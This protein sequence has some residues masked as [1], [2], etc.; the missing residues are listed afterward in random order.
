MIS[1]HKRAA[2]YD[3]DIPIVALGVDDTGDAPRPLRTYQL[4][5]VSNLLDAG[6]PVAARAVAD[7]YD[8]QFHP[9]T[10]R[11]WRRGV[12]KGGA[13]RSRWTYAYLVLGP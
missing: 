6:M 10:L 1:L 3:Y 11:R 4:N 2:G 7:R 5:V 8:V 9:K 13:S 12:F